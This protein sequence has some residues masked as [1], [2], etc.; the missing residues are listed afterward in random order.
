MFSFNDSYAVLNSGLHFPELT[1]CVTTPMKYLGFGSGG[2]DS[3]TDMYHS[4]THSTFPS[5]FRQVI[6]LLLLFLPLSLPKMKKECVKT[7]T[8]LDNVVV[9]KI[10]VRMRCH[11]NLNVFLT[12]LSSL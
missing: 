9:Y 5:T 6:G 1:P 10:F 3:S 11:Q 7:L 8:T 12:L 2:F 4:P